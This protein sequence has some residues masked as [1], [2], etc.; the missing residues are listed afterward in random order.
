M[1]YCKARKAEIYYEDLGEGIPI[2]MI[3]GFSPDHRLMKGCMEPLFKDRRGWRRIYMDLP[4]MG[5]TKNYQ[6]VSTTDDMLESVIELIDYL[7][8]N[9]DYVIAGESYGGYLA[10]GIIHKQLSRVKGA[11][12]ICPVIYPDSIDRSLVPHKVMRRDESFLEG[13]SH[14]EIEDFSQNNVVLNEYTWK[15]YNQEILSGVKQSDSTLLTRVQENYGFSFAV[16]Q[17]EFNKP[18]VFLMGRQDSV[19]GF[20]DALDLLNKFS[21]GTFGIIDEAGHNLQIEKQDVFNSLM[22]DWLDR[23]EADWK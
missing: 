15:R 1:P 14:E 20:Q 19:V 8:P 12:F 16:N 6:D 13:L 2:I 23:V 7:I 18:S 22:N 3:H 11:G 21:R 5:R 4:G 10:R 9:Q 17:Y